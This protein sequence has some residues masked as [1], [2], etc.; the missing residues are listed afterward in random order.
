MAKQSLLLVDG[1]ARSLRVLEVSLKKA[2]FN[3]TTAVTGRDALDKVQTALPDLIISDT[4]MSEMDGFA[5]CKKLKM[6]PAWSDIPFI[7][8]TKESSIENKIRGLEL[9]V[10]D[11]LTKPIYIKEILTRIRIL[12]QKHQRARLEGKRDQKTTFSGRISDLGVVDLIQTIEISRKSGLIQVRASEEQRAVVYFRDG[13]VIDAET[14]ALQGADAVYRLLTWS[15]GEFEVLFRNVRRKEVIK[16]SSQALL[17]EG[18]RRLD[19]WGRLLEQLPTL[20]TVFVVD[21]FE[22]AERL[23]ELP[24]ELNS[25]LKLFDGRRNLMDV[26]DASDFSD[27]ECLEVIAK[28]YFEGLILESEA[29]APTRPVTV[30]PE[31]DASFFAM[32][33]SK[34]S[35]RAE[36][37]RSSTP[38]PARDPFGDDRPAPFTA[39]APRFGTESEQTIS[40]EELEMAGVAVAVAEQTSLVEAAI[41]AATPLLPIG[42]PVF[43]SEPSPAS[44][45]PSAQPER[46]PT[47]R[48]GRAATVH[49]EPA[50]AV[51]QPTAPGKDSAPIAVV[52]S[53]GAEVATA[54]GEFSISAIEA[55]GSHTAREIVTIKPQRLEDLEP[56]DAPQIPLPEPEPAAESA[57]EPESEPEPE[58]ESEPDIEPEG[59]TKAIAKA[60]TAESTA[61]GK[62]REAYEP[63]E[64]ARLPR[65][66]AVL[67]DDDDD[68]KA[69]PDDDG[70]II[71]IEVESE[72]LEDETGASSEETKAGKPEDQVWYDLE[73]DDDKKS[74]PRTP[75]VGP[76]PDRTRTSS[77][78]N[79][80]LYAIIGAILIAIIIFIATRSG[81]GDKHAANTVAIDAGVPTP[82]PLDAGSGG[83]PP[84][85]PDAAVPTPAIDATVPSVDAAVKSH[86][87][88]YSEAKRA[89]R[90]K[91]YDEAIVAIDAALELRGSAKYLVFKAEILLEADKPEDALDVVGKAVKKSSSYHKGWAVKGEVHMLMGQLSDAKE[92]YQRFLRYEPTGPQADSVREI[93]RTLP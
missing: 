78:G 83:P 86:R 10:E 33:V 35:S 9:G 8:L 93:L 42:E 27:L 28:L 82:P 41:G 36:F 57:L 4:D 18:M 1:D 76:L 52:S 16:I 44:P 77:S 17:M 12:L 73:D 37:S 70:E 29:D 30:N 62:D 92:A 43:P 84:P 46:Q 89:L 24:D 39:R 74:K 65:R 66:A 60:D 64:T 88:F 19:E 25:I 2:G 91:K 71:A 31:E 54:S 7:F 38:P 53:E 45:A 47:T 67:D 13:K 34:F 55:Q 68:S 58:P 51:P 15:D 72:V 40:H 22:L 56:D 87:Q 59:P 11:Y 21:S 20:D 3:V 81:D 63:A 50:D 75:A 80:R 61:R 69:E 49:P 79:L 85:A 6:N 26:V 90:R 23:A 48:P 14:G 5:F 32:A